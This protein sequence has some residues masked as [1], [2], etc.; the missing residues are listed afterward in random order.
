LENFQDPSEFRALVRLNNHYLISCVTNSSIVPDDL[1]TLG[2]FVEKHLHVKDHTLQLSGLMVRYAKLSSDIRRGVLS[3]TECIRIAMELDEELQVVEFE[4]PLSWQYST[5]LL[6]QKSSQA[7]EFHFDSYPHRNTCQAR[8]ILR[9]VRMLLNECLVEQYL[10]SPIG[11][12][13]SALVRAAYDNIERLAAEICASVPQYVDCDGAARKKLPT[14][15]TS[16]LSDVRPEGNRDHGLPKPGHLHT[17]HH[18]TDCYSLIFALYA[19]GRSKAVQ[20]VRPWVIKQLHYIGSHFYVRH[21][22]IVA[23]ILERE[24]DPNVW[25]VYTML[26]SYAFNA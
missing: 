13:Q 8:N 21:A 11:A 4:L 19:A 14:S 7:F 5:T 15:E 17:P 25:H 16:S 12:G 24:N 20:D 23:Q 6:N 22:E 2:N 26:G 3:K 9:V 18:K 10:A 1:I